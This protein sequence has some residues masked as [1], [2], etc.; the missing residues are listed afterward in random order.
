MGGGEGSLHDIGGGG[1]SKH[2]MTCGT[3]TCMLLF[4]CVVLHV[5]CAVAMQASVWL[6]SP[7]WTNTVESNGIISCCWFDVSAYRGI[8]RHE[9][10]IRQPG[11]VAVRWESTV[12]R[13][14]TH[15]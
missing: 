8:G 6:E 14:A 7:V 11:P 15:Y 9:F 3:V 1:M 10:E 2:T 4:F 12:A 5:R 13:W